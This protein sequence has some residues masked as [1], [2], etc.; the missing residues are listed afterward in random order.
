MSKSVV[1]KYR[2]QLAERQFVSMPEG[3]QILHFDSQPVDQPDGHTFAL[4]LWAVVDPSAANEDRY[5][6]VVGTGNPAE[7]LDELSHIGTTV[8][9]SGY[10]WH[11]FEGSRG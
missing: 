11:L 5:F 6:R 8:L 4:C 9:P 7:D 10:V 1:W 2:L 3:A